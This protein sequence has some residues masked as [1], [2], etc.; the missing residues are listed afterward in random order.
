MLKAKKGSI[1]AAAKKEVLRRNEF[2]GFYVKLPADQY[3][4][5]QD[6]INNLRITKLEWLSEVVKQIE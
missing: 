5:L 2:K 3:W 6:H 4:K 1:V